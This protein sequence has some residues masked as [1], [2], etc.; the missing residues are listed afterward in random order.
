V[1]DEFSR[2][3]CIASQT[4]QDI[5]SMSG[6]Q[7]TIIALALIIAIQRTDPA[8]FY[9]FDEI[10]AALDPV[11]RHAVADLIKK[12]SESEVGRAQFLVSTF[13]DEMVKPADK[14]Y[15]ISFKDHVRAV[16]ACLALAQ[17][18]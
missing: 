12:Q 3:C 15:G 1:L 7:N 2:F 5:M 4:S 16:G 13:K 10:D 9:V 6:G 8:P 18:V 11:Y 14:C 17:R